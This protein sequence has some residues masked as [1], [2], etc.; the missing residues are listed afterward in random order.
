M[1]QVG[2]QEAKDDFNGK[3]EVCT[4]ETVGQ[5][6]AVGYFFGRQLHQTLDVP[7]GLIDNAWGGSACEAWVRRDILEGDPK[8]APLIDR[9]EKMEAEYASADT[10]RRTQA[11]AR[12]PDARQRPPRQHLQRRAQAHHRLR[13]PRRDL[14]PGRIQRRPRLPVPRPVSAHDPELARRVGPRRLPLLLGPARRLHGRKT[15][16]PSTATGPSSAKPRP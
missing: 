2:T 9:W 16:N 1:P 14:V 11:A 8:Y 7:I 10:K 4:P 13:H 15:P 12:R 3:W 6:S 5:F